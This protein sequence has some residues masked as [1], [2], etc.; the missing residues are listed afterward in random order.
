MQKTRLAVFFGGV[1]SEH[2]ISLVSAA[3]VLRH[4]PKDSFS[5]F[6]V[7][8]TKQGKWL[9]YTG[10]IDDI[11][12]GKWEK[13][14][15]NQPV[16]ISP[17]PEDRGF[18]LPDSGERIRVDCAFPVLHGKNG[19]D[20]SIQGI[21]EIAG[22]PYVGCGILSSAAC[23]D[24]S[25][26]HI[27]AERQGI[28]MAR[29]KLI[30]R[31]QQESVIPFAQ[32][33][34]KELGLPLFV[35]PANAG[36]SVGISKAHTEEELIYA[37]KIAFQHD[38][39]VLVEEAIEGKEIEC[40][41]LGE[42]H[43]ISSIPGQIQPCNEFYDYEA[44]YQA[45][46]KLI[47]PADIDE[48]IAKEMQKTAVKAFLALDCSGLARVDFFVNEK[49][50]I[51]LNEINTMPG[52]TSISMYPKLWEKSGVSYSALLQKLIALAMKKNEKASASIL[53]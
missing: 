48:S 45:D 44:K 21:F 18:F 9:Y 51:I 8:I 6:C 42:K 31:Y 11:P 15:D 32:S 17:N 36:S 28:A 22:I 27:L 29:W 7:G 46:S 25:V 37:I 24:K 5:V 16:F 10:P 43:P 52:F 2:E 34:M 19:E 47:I 4:I 23:M 13:H 53:S 39:K 33:A 41:V 35:K 40:A 1:S 3:S 26:T 38:D 14:P 49:Q 12:D 30:R 20:G 50:E